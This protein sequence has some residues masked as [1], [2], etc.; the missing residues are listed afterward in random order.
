FIHRRSGAAATTWSAAVLLFPFVEQTPAYDAL[1]AFDRM[2][3]NG[4]VADGDYNTNPWGEDDFASPMVGPFPT[5][6]CPSDG[7][8]RLPCPSFTYPGGLRPARSSIRWCMGDGMWHCGE[9]WDRTGTSLTNPRTYTRGMFFPCHRK[10]FSDITD[11]TAN[12][13][14]LSESASPDQ[15]STLSIKSGITGGTT[16]GIYV[17]GSVI[18]ENCLNNGYSADR[19]QLVSASNAQRGLIFGD[20]RSPNV[21]FHTVLPPNGPSCGHNIT[22]GGTNGWG[23]FSATSYHPGGVSVAFMD[24]TVRFVT[25]TINTGD[26]SMT[27]GGHHESTGTQPVQS[28][29]SNYGV[30]GALGTPSAGDHEAF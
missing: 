11:G 14:A 13:V 22:S 25:D 23:V 12:T 21:G 9:D 30:W 6:L 4:D 26:L 2:K 16:S 7:E 27:Q 5:F 20:G 18:P 28:G 1:I 19:S 17:S 15:Q 8:A 10:A 29:G 24:G 3:D